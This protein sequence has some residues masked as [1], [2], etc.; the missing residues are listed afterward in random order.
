MS[1]SLN[2]DENSLINAQYV[3]YCPTQS[4]VY[5]SMLEDPD[6]EG[7]T[8][9]AVYYPGNITNGE[10]YK[11]LGTKTYEV[12]DLIYKKVKK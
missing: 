11:Y 5:N 6:F 1:S 2:I 9:L 10:I 12:Y 3:G 7:I 4:A 8:D